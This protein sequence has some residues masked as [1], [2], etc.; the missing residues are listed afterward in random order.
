MKQEIEA[1]DARA[2]SSPV[3]VLSFRRTPHY[4]VRIE[5]GY[6]TGEGRRIRRR[7]SR[8]RPFLGSTYKPTIGL[9]PPP[10]FRL[11]HASVHR[12]GVFVI[13]EHA[14]IMNIC[15]RRGR[16][17]CRLII[18]TLCFVLHVG[19]SDL[20]QDRVKPRSQDLVRLFNG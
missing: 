8:I 7:C 9:S 1:L 10:Y 19:A 2:D 11:L 17:Q 14:A 5:S 13:N 4:A 6:D 3:L 12:S 15:R 18:G 16:D 20:C